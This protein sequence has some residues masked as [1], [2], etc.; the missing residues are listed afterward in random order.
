MMS[1]AAFR[2]RDALFSPSAAIT[3]EG[4]KAEERCSDRIDPHHTSRHTMLVS[5]YSVLRLVITNRFLLSAPRWNVNFP[6]LV[7]FADFVFRF[8]TIPLRKFHFNSVL[9]R[10]HVVVA[11]GCHAKR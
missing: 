11:Y 2:A 7:I 8:I 6:S 5:S 9:C 3:C 4:K 10:T 1:A